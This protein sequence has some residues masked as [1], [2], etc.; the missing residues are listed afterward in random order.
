[1]QKIISS[2]C[3]YYYAIRFGNK[4]K[5]HNAILRRV[6]IHIADAQNIAVYDNVSVFDSEFSIVGSGNSFR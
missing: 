5:L 3:K 6:K 2:L 1:M 4:L